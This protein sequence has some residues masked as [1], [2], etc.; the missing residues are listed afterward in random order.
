MAGKMAEDPDFFKKN[1]EEKY[2][3]FARAKR[4]GITADQFNGFINRN[5]ENAKRE[6][7]LKEFDRESAEGR[8]WLN[9]KL[10]QPSLNQMG[11]PTPSA[12]GRNIGRL[13]TGKVSPT[14]TEVR[15]SV[16]EF[17]EDERKRQRSRD[18]GRRKIEGRRGR[19]RGNALSERFKPSERFRRMRAETPTMKDEGLDKE[20]RRGKRR[21]RR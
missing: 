20:R 2:D 19:G 1:R 15:E 18:R 13:K 17:D 8:A 14:D 3:L 10:D 21:S 6:H 16:R 11:V 5:Y 9:E 12:R 7:K 4:L